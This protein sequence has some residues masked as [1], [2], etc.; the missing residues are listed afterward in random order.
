MEKK[1]IEPVPGW[2]KEYLVT[3]DGQVWSVAYNK[4]RSLRIKDGYYYIRLIGAGKDVT[5]SVHRLVAMTFVPN[6]KNKPQ[7]NHI[8]GNKLNNHF[9]NLEWC[10]NSEN[11]LHAHKH[12]LQPS[13][14]GE[15][16][17]NNK[18]SAHEVDSIRNSG[19]RRKQV[20]LKYPHISLTTIDRILKNKSW[21]IN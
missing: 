19:M 21:I 3:R 9:S 12:N 11:Q 16:N 1:L 13:R 4:W 6:P 17:G 7:V 14:K 18:L 15:R 8:D 20:K 5:I 10:T 2:E